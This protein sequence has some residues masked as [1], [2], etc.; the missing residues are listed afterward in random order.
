[1][2]LDTYLESGLCA[3][4]RTSY[5][6]VSEQQRLCKGSKTA[7]KCGGGGWT[8]G[9]WRDAVASGR[10]ELERSVGRTALDGGS[11]GVCRGDADGVERVKRGRRGLR[12]VYS[13]AG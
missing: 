4:Q 10:D 11:R 8:E 3:R 2:G 5:Y 13:R 7:G 6:N 1:M 12:W 9:R